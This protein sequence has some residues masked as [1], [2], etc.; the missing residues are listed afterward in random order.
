MERQV[1]Y[2]LFLKEENFDNYTDYV[3][4]NKKQKYKRTCGPIDYNGV[5]YKLD[6]KTGEMRLYNRSEYLGSRKMSL[7]RTKRLLG[8]LLECNDFD[9]FCTLTFDKDKIH[10][11][12]E[13]EVFGA[14]VKFIHNLGEQFPTLKYI[15]V[16][17]YHKNFKAIHFH[18]LLGGV[19]WKKLGLENSGKVCCH[20]SCKNGICSKEYFE[21][22]KDSHVLK[23]T[24]GLTVYNITSFIYGFTTATRIV[25]RER[26]NSYIKKYIGKDLGTTEF[27][28][29]R[30]YYS[31]NLNVPYLVRRCI[32]ADF[33]SP[34]DVREIAKKNPLLAHAD[35]SGYF[36]DYN[37]FFAR[38]SNSTKENISKGLVSINEDTPFD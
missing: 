4:Y 22:T 7:D 28:K 24:D 14:Y 17:E 16:V 10:R 5:R 6:F 9:W 18:L 21:K 34:Q 19:P 11:Q 31:S 15:T 32:G 20:W 25:S 38:V 2:A 8:L 13:E 12:S 35:F 23:D 1:K 29:K 26:C 30:F 3:L 36:E 27:F 37:L 33:D